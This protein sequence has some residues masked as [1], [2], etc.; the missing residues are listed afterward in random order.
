MDHR[1]WTTLAILLVLAATTVLADGAG[2][3][4]GAPTDRWRP[5]ETELPVQ[6]LSERNHGACVNCCKELSGLPGNVCSHFCSFRVPPPPGEPQ[7]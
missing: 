3:P 7:P 6:C 4:A 2:A 5:A 1:P